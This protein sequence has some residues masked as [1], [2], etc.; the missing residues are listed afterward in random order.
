MNLPVQGGDESPHSKL[1]QVFT[2]L[3]ASFAIAGLLF[4]YAL[5][6][7][8]VVAAP[9][10]ADRFILTYGK[11]NP[12]LPALDS[13]AKLTVKLELRH[14]VFYAPPA[15]KGEA[16]NV[17]SIAVGQDF[18]QGE[19]DPAA[20]VAIFQS[21]VKS[22]NA[23]G[24][25]GVYVVPNRE[26]I[27]PQTQEDFRPANQR[28]LTLVIWASEIGEVRTVAKGTRIPA[29]KGV[30]NRKH[31]RI[32]NHSP[33][34]AA[35]A[36]QP[37]SLLYKDW[38]E[39][40]LER[41]NRQPGRRVESAISSTSDPGE[42]ILDY[43]VNE[44]RAWF[45]YAQVSNT[46]TSAT[47]LWRERIGFT[48]TQLTNHDDVL[49]FDYITS[50]FS[51]GNAAFLSYDFPIVFP[52]KL[53]VR[54]LLSYGNFTARDVGVALEEFT[55]S[56]WTAGLEATYSPFRF[57][58]FAF[59]TTLG[60]AWQEV[61]VNN[62]TIGLEGKAPLF[63][64]YLNMKLDRLTETAA[65]SFQ[66]GVETNLA[67]VAGTTPEDIFPLGRLQTDVNYVM[68][69]FEFSQ[70][71]YLEPLFFRHDYDA[72]QNWR[73]STRA[74]EVSLT[75]RG[76]EI[77]DDKRVIPQKQL[78]IGGLYSV[79]GYPE[80]VSGGDNVA[81]LSAEYRYHIPRSF[82][83]YADGDTRRKARPE[84]PPSYFG[85]PFYWRPGQVY[86]LPDWDLIFRTFFD[87]GYTN[88]VRP[89]P[90]ESD[91]KLMSSGFGFE[92]QAASRL[93]L[94]ADWGLVLH[95]VKTGNADVPFGSS[96][97]HFSASFMW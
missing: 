23:R 35:A 22:I 28:S 17:E 75:V 61:E 88:I 45:T 52:D 2:G 36:G 54:A 72:G 57:W 25:Y 44:K 19:F 84:T 59:D 5:F 55:G 4:V 76:Q 83:P 39:D 20:L 50:S 15:G 74:H 87:A 67:S 27:D 33:L 78:A 34:K 41:L 69:K 26:E 80:S 6:A 81:Y 47:S 90:E 3:R 65:T 62:R 91:R 40:Y 1:G 9:I 60:A 10:R 82:R 24:I 64:P 37:G 32:L 85:Q 53:R 42:V 94:R 66:V 63:T 96:R 13:F 31:R 14:G 93:T 29:D 71:M 11:T 21:I 38:L 49:S 43:L 46:G 18:P 56:S 70:S 12:K 8:P 68:L 77:L 51:A 79:R 89:R 73:R 30:D 92:F 7:S 86:G 48:D 97:V 95:R 58:G 16:K